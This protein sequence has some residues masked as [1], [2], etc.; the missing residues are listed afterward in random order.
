MSS[1]LMTQIHYQLHGYRSG[2]QLLHSS[3]RL[4]RR[5]QDLIDRLSDMAGPLRPGETFDPY[6]SCYP[7][8]SE[9]FYVLSRTRQ[10]IDAPRAGCVVTKTILVPSHY[11]ESDAH[12]PTLIQLL[13]S[14]DFIEGPFRVAEMG[15][16]STTRPVIDGILPEL[17]EALF[18]EKR[19]P[20]VVFAAQEAEPISIRLLTALWPAMRRGFSV[21][22]LSLAPRFLLGKPFDLLFAPKTA[23]SR[24]SEW[25]GR[26]IDA[27]GKENDARHRWTRPLVRRVFE[28]EFPSLI[29]RDIA[30]LLARKTGDESALRLTFM[31]EE[32]QEKAQKSPTAVLGLLDIANS[33][34]ILIDMWPSLEPS[35]L[36][37]VD[38]T[39]KYSSKD[40]AWKFFRDLI[41]KLN[42]IPSVVLLSVVGKMVSLVHQDFSAA[43]RNLNT[44]D[45]SNI[46][47]SKPMLRAI[48]QYIEPRTIKKAAS[49]LVILEPKK[50]LQIVRLKPKIISFISSDLECS[51]ATLLFENLSKELG[52]SSVQSRFA[53]LKLFAN[54]FQQVKCA[55]LLH[56]L[57]SGLDADIFI[58]AASFIWPRSH[59]P[60]IGEVL[61]EL[62]IKSG[63]QEA[64]REIFTITSGSTETNILILRLTSYS[65]ADVDWLLSSNI[66]GRNRAELLCSFIINGD[67]KQ[68]KSSFANVGALEKTIDL[69][70]KAPRKHSKA[71]S[72]LLELKVTDTIKSVRVASV[73]KKYIPPA[74]QHRFSSKIIEGALSGSLMPAE[75]VVDLVASFPE[76]I[77]VDILLTH[78]RKKS[79]KKLALND[80]LGVFKDVKGASLHVSI[81]NMNFLVEII[82]SDSEF[83]LSESA[84]STLARIVEW[85][86]GE[87][88]FRYEQVSLQLLPVLM[89]SVNSPSSPV[90]VVTF[91]AIYEML[92]RED[93][94]FN[95]S[96]FFFFTD[97]D[98]CKVARKNLVRSFLWSKWPPS[99]LARVAYSS[100]DMR[101]VLKDLV[102]EPGGLE[103]LSRLKLSSDELEVDCRREI[104]REL[105]R[106]RPE[107]LNP[108]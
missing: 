73:I 56:G 20:I 9:T 34:K 54:G 23:R 72:I 12:V 6:L 49:E 74:D 13:E 91:P 21:C 100:R 32:L 26:R 63:V 93:N 99:D 71:I 68:I 28:S 101:R 48:A 107:N 45:S 16:F 36:N 57:L 52:S 80:V 103:Y 33:K 78:I 67:K 85:L 102:E 19:E 60:E 95:F 18:L 87:D 24:F 38:F 30:S 66:L 97:W 8:P 2:H 89:N 86:R 47:S 83:F 79:E 43:L 106:L 27:S 22:T 3:I 41:A 70:M 25:P 75:L 31:W 104:N 40:I 14:E 82:T 98:K 15:S 11:W 61:C 64:V 77:D 5:D 59:M 69:L 105:N 44:I 50:L 58:K 10:D 94:Y 88:Y 90:I 96:K 29:S 51:Q 1:Q 53:W 55:P 7:L 42:A 4:E 17:L 65:A 76:M 35:V 84:A 37:A 39:M 46:L 108:D 62:A 81:D 92:K